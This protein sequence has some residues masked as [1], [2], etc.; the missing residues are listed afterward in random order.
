MVKHDQVLG[1]LSELSHPTKDAH[2]RSEVFD[3]IATA[4]QKLLNDIIN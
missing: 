4:N 1:Y 2:Q 3:I